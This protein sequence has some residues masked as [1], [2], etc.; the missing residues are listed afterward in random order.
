MKQIIKNNI[1]LLL[2][3]NCFIILVLY[4][5]SFIKIGYI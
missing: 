4:I 2:F 5:Y 1:K 3:H